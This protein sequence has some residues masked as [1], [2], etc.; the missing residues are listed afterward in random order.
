MKIAFIVLIA[1]I[2]MVA[3]IFILLLVNGNLSSV[4][5][6]VISIVTGQLKLSIGG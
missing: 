2:L 1:V 4:V 5:S 6:S 3:I